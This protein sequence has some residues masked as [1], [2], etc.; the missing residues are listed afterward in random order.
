MRRP[1][2]AP[3]LASTRRSSTRAMGLCCR[4]SPGARGRDG[5]AHGASDARVYD[6]RDALQLLLAP[7][8]L[9]FV[10]KR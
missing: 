1:S 9:P 4:S 2:G 5:H 6:R 7:S 8:A 3:T 10:L